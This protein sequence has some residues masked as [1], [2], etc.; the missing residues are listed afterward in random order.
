[1][2]ARTLAL[3]ALAAASPLHAEEVRAL[4]GGGHYGLEGSVVD[5]GVH[6]DFDDDLGLELQRRRGFALEVDTPPGGWPDFTVSYTPLAASGQRSEPVTFPFPATRTILTNA[7]FDIH[8]VVVRWPLN[9]GRLRASL[10]VTVQRLE[11]ELVI[12]DNQ[13]A[14]QRHE[15]YDEVFP[16]LHVQL[17]RAT[18]KF[19]LETVAQGI[20]YD[21]SRALE[22]R[23]LAEARFLGPFTVQFGWQ[24]RRYRIELADYALDA[25]VR[26]ALL[27]FG[28][29]YR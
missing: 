3:T 18:R 7:D 14:R 13:E 27:R 23:A 25:R 4:F 19:A 12:D 20:S 8:E 2:L 9:Q 16:Q 6:Y 1:M 11:G 26:G 10:G 22:W 5:R 29:L 24:E 17:R 15:H 28:V 21:G